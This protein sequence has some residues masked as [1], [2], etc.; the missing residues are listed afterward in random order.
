M[1]LARAIQMFMPGKPQVWYLD[2]FVGKNDHEAVRLA[3]EGGHKE[4]NRTNLSVSEVEERL[5]MD[6]VKNQIALLQLRNTHPAFGEDAEIRVDSE[7]S[8]LYI[9]WK[10]GEAKIA[11]SANL[12]TMEYSIEK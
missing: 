9:E 4:I 12:K 8:N 6:V 1:E 3:G 11:L 5:K 2:L 10:R 7:G